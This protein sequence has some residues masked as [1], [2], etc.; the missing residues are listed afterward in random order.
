M[1]LRVDGKRAF[2]A[3]GGRTHRPGRPA[4]ILVHGAGMDRTVWVL[5]TRYFA[6]HGHN[7]LAVDLPGHGRSEGPSLASI[8]DMAEWLS[9]VMD[10]AGVE[11]ASVVGHSMG[12][13]VA[14]ELC[15]GFS[16]RV[17]AAVLLST[18]VPMPVSEGLLSAAKANDHDAIDMIV[19]WGHGRSAHLGGHEAPGLWMTGGAERLLEKAGDGVL[20]TDLDAC[21][22]YRD[23][24][25]AASRVRCPVLLVLGREDRMTPPRA[26]RELADA[27]P[28]SR[29]VVLDA[30]GHMPM[31]ERPDRV[32]DVLGEAIRGDPDAV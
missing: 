4:V 7:V 12:S 19:A 23:G 25:E 20:Y 26:A 24:L 11:T 31:V 3:T 16:E 14:L 32:L 17:D 9:R 8:G 5:Q 18:A 22:G 6:H 15:A 10:A 27:I 1:E 2:A 29:T 13:L 21:D 30:C 28:S